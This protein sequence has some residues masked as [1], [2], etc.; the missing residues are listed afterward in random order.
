MRYALELHPG[1]FFL[2]RR[3]GEGSWNGL[4]R[5]NDLGVMQTRFA[6]QLEIQTPGTTVRLIDCKGKVLNEHTA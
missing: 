6:Y 3:S 2:E 4:S 1:E 5:D